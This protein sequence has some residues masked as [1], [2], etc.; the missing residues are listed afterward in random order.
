MP[1][2]SRARA[3]P[4]GRSKL[5]DALHASSL[6]DLARRSSAHAVDEDEAGA[7]RDQGR[8]DHVLT[9]AGGRHAHFAVDAAL[10]GRRLRL[11]DQE[12]HD[13]DQE[14][15]EADRIEGREDA[16]TPATATLDEA[17]R[18]CA[19]EAR[20]GGCESRGVRIASLFGHER[21]DARSGG[22]LGDRRIRLSSNEI[23]PARSLRVVDV[24]HALGARRDRDDGL[25]APGQRGLGARRRADVHEPRLV[26]AS[27]DQ[28][29]AAI[30]DG[31]AGAC[32]GLVDD[33]ESAGGQLLTSK[34]RLESD[35]S[36]TS[37]APRAPL[38]SGRGG[39]PQGRWA[40]A[41]ARKRTRR[42]RARR[43]GE[44][45]GA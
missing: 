32:R 28:H 23:L 38:V 21:W 39:A 27:R 33:A 25:R 31:L 44:R 41:E 24:L 36:A 4:R 17:Q 26:G 1:P 14:V 40:A 2:A 15:D 45:R 8:L 11:R 34:L 37:T 30:A 18:R 10:A 35:L 13:D 6:G 43:G 29:D 9:V 3:W 16:A 22:R 19:Q 12:H 42:G 20:A 5:V 7:H